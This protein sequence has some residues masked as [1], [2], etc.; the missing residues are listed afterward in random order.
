MFRRA[1]VLASLLLAW[2]PAAAGAETELNVIP[3]GQHEPGVAWASAAGHAARQRAGADVRPPHAARPQRHRRGA[4]AERRRHGLLQVRQAARARRP[5]ADHRRDDQRERADGADPARRLRRPAHLLRHRRRASSSA[6]ATSSPRTATCCSTRRATTASR[7]RSTCPACRRS[8]S[9]AACTT[10]SRPPRCAPRSTR[11]Q[12][13]ALKAAGRRAGRCCAT[14]TPTSSASTSG[15]PE[16]AGRAALRPRGHLRHQRDQGPVPRRGRR[17]GGRRTRCSS[18]PRATASAPARQRGLRG[19]APAQR[20]R[21]ADDQRRPAPYQTG[22]P[23]RR[24]ARSRAARAGHASRAGAPTLPG[25]GRGRDAPGPRTKASNV[26][27]VD[28]DRSATGTPIFV[29]GPQI[30]YNYPGLTLE[31]GLYGPTIRARGATSAPFPGYMLI[32]RGENFAWSLTSAEADI[33]DTYAERLCGGSRTRYRY[34]GKCRRMQ[35]VDAGTIRRAARQVRVA[36]PPHGARPGGRATR[37]SPAPGGSSR[38]RASASS[39]GRETTDQIFFQRLTYGR[40]K[41][42]A[43]FVAAAQATPQTFNSFYADDKRHRVLHHRPAAGAPQGRQRRPAGRRPRPVRVERLP[44]RLAPSPGRRPGQRAARQLEQQAGAGLPR[45][46]RPLGRGR[47]ARASTGCCRSSRASRSTRPRP[48]SAP[49]TRARRPIRAVL[50]PA[51]TAVLAKGTAPSPLAPRWPT[52]SPLERRRRG[53]V[54][55]NGD[56][57]STARARPRSARSGP[58][59]PAPPCAAGSARRCARC[60]RPPPALHQP[61]PAA[62]TAAGTST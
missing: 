51:V 47:H 13:A 61:P 60:S 39:A 23:V 5:V 36:L 18:T 52:S 49:T 17:P 8:T 25:A 38:W 62:C 29:G 53:W 40:V 21:D 43:D 2:T 12:D 7:P 31:M 37:A 46:R 57:T 56:G 33:I 14:S 55:A 1:P 19:P 20:S 48:C 3:H 10:T 45:R 22:R 35:T 41:S 24:R 26:L 58:S 15:T 44:P 42:A 27:L 9:P 50:W 34:K 28:G 59:W 30:G 54:D 4:E 16:P 32:G 11:R 6:P